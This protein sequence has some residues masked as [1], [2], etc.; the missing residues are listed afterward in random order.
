MNLIKTISALQKV[1][2]RSKRFQRGVA[3]VE[4]ALSL[5]I[6]L[7]LM[8]GTW[9]G[10]YAMLVNEKT[11]RIAYSVTDIVSQYQK[12]TLANLNDIILAAGQLMQPFPFA[13]NGRVIVTSVYKPAGQAAYICWQY[14]GGGTL[15][16]T[17]RIG[18]TGGAPSLPNGLMLNDNDNII[19]SEVFYNFTPIFVNMNLFTSGLLYRT[20][21]YK[22]RLSPLITQPS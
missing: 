22:P 6:W 20:V 11:D 19:I 15:T 1:Q 12:I 9:D 16:Q 3:A 7:T 10:A 17:S 5:P 21:I 8:L 4:F 18:T 2:A 14:S 13:T